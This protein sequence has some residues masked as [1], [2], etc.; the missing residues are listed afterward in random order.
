MSGFSTAWLDLR[1]P[2]DASAR[3]GRLL[4]DAAALVDAADDA[5]VIDLGSGTG[6]TL[7]ALQPALKRPASWILVDADMDLLMEAERRAEG[8]A[9]VE[10]MRFDLAAP[11]PLPLSD[12]TLVT[13]SALFDLVSPA[14]LDRLV[15]TVAAN[16]SALYAALTY[17]GTTTWSVTH[18]LDGEVLAA[19]NRHQRSDKGFGPA[20]GPAAAQA[21]AE[22]L[23]RAGYRVQAA[24]SPWRLGPDDAALMRPLI[25]GMADAV[26]AEGS[27]DAASVAEWRTFRLETMAES[28]VTVGHVDVLAR[29]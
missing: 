2:A 18:P 6:S 4:A 21:L 19:F 11:R 8:L 27:L 25:D 15:A 5:L 20:L 24:A 12:A 10:V 17:D 14:F 26:T 9:G 29:L 3:D 13:A 1:E 7:R 16:R 28:R 22:A 23:S